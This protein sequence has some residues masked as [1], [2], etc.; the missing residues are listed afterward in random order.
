LQL[1]LFEDGVEFG[2]VDNEVKPYTSNYLNNISDWFEKICINK[3]FENKVFN[4]IYQFKG[5]LFTHVW[6]TQLALPWGVESMLG[7]V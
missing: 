6:G 7:L 4:V 5:R 1:S 2:G 3:E